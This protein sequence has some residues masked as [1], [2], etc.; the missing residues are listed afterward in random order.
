MRWPER[1]FGAQRSDGRGP[2][3]R[4]VAL[5]RN[6]LGS[7][8]LFFMMTA[9]KLAA[10]AKQLGEMA[11]NAVDPLFARSL[12]QRARQWQAMADE[13][14]ILHH[15]PLYRSIHDRPALQP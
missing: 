3:A 12:R 9:Q 1:S 2:Q 15:D 13:I 10:K 4:R 8:A 7:L 11:D 14:R 5:S 6:A